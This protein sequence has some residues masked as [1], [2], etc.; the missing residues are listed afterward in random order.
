[1]ITSEAPTP[2]NTVCT[3]TK[4]KTNKK[5]LIIKGYYE[6]SNTFKCIL[7]AL[8][9]HPHALG[10]VPCL[11]KGQICHLTGTLVLMGSQAPS[12]NSHQ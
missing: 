3:T 4:N 1:M 7:I 9:Q 6:F 2:V 11:P 10:R 5:P 8:H 12:N